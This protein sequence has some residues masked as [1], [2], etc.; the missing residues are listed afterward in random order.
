MKA[1]LVGLLFLVLVGI[2][3][4]VGFAGWFLLLPLFMV[5]GLLLRVLFVFFLFVLVVW[6]VGKF[7]LYVI[8]SLKNI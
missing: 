6:L 3:A 1:F 4:A 5:L 2:L 7:V 8:H